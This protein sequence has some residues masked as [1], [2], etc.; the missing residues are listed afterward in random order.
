MESTLIT[1]HMNMLRARK[2]GT[3]AGTIDGTARVQLPARPIFITCMSPWVDPAAI[4]GLVPGD[5]YVIRSAG[6]VVTQEAVRSILLAMMTDT[7]S[8]IIVLGHTE[9]TN[10]NKAKV[11][12]KLDAF[13]ARL[14]QRNY[15][16]DV[17][18]TRENATKYFGL[19]VDEIEN[20]F[21]QLENLRFLKVIQPRLNITGMLYNVKN[22]HVLTLAELESIRSQRARGSNIELDDIIPARYA[23][24]V[25]A[26]VETRVTSSTNARRNQAMTTGSA[27][28]ISEPGRAAPVTNVD[29]DASPEMAPVTMMNLAGSQAIAP[30]QKEFAG[31][32]LAFEKLM[33]AMQK[34]I[35]KATAVRIFMPKI[36]PPRVAGMTQPPPAAGDAR[37]P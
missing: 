18:G 28:S 21:T 6:N 36:R 4:F 14:P 33:E 23:S 5:A 24:R 15:Y 12:K 26:H 20:V 13:I 32:Q 11:Y 34:S 10:A 3:G 19:F 7:V 31:Q 37:S 1:N 16:R 25:E 29:S 22:G 2:E 9:C 30:L 35:S 8:D 27:P 17:L